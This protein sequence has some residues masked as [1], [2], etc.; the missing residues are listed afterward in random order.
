MT[1]EVII[2]FS[3]PKHWKIGAEC[4]K[5]WSKSNF[6]HVYIV[7]NR[8]YVGREIVYQ[9]SH[10][11]V[12]CISKSNFLKENEI[13]AEFAVPMSTVDYCNTIQ[14]CIDNLGADYGQIGLIKIVLSKKLKLTGDG[15]KTFHCSELAIRAVPMLKFYLTCQLE[16]DFI[17][18][19]HLE[20]C[21]NYMSEL[22]L[23]RKLVDIYG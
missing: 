22:N 16:P 18:P 1:R 12:N 9:A 23:S 13:V 8:R 17:E 6:S 19:V 10:G 11:N 3:R 14:Y 2:G 4:I 15:S 21:L 7:E 5:R 20:Q